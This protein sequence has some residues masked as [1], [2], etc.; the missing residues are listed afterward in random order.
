MRTKEEIQAE[1]IFIF[2]NNL[3]YRH[4]SSFEYKMVISH[5]NMLRINYLLEELSI[6]A[7]WIEDQSFMYRSQQS[8]TEINIVFDDGGLGD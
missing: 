2:F 4:D 3:K 8:K 6:A 7:Y 1:I 5:K